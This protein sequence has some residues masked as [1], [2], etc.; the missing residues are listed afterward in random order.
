M[1]RIRRDQQHR[2]CELVAHALRP[3]GAGRIWLRRDPKLQFETGL[4]RLS[5]FERDSSGWEGPSLEPEKRSRR[6]RVS[7]D[8]P[9]ERE[10]RRNVNRPSR[11]RSFARPL[12]MRSWGMRAY[13]L[14]GP[15]IWKLLG[16]KNGRLPESSA[17]IFRFKSLRKSERCAILI[18]MSE[19]R[20]RPIGGQQGKPVETFCTQLEMRVDLVYFIWRNPLKSLDSEK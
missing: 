6:R 9:K 3:A 16:G 10:R 13:P 15:V 11:R 5:E 20:A 4:E 19:N 14:A 7:K 2:S 1:F 8:A 18:W 17:P 12:R